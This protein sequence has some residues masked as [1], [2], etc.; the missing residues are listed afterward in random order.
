LGK[1]FSKYDLHIQ[2]QGDVGSLESCE[3]VIFDGK[4]YHIKLAR[5]Y[6]YFHLLAEIA[7]KRLPVD[8]IESSTASLEDI[9]AGL[10]RG[11]QS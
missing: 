8:T 11:D 4:G 2:S 6:D 7:K 10:S 5:G 9:F 3:D 1:A